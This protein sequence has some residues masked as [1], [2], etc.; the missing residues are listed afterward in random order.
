MLRPC[1]AHQLRRSLLRMLQY[2]G[3]AAV[4]CTPNLLVAA[5]LSGSFYG[6]S[7]AWLLSP[8]RCCTPVAPMGGALL[9]W[10][11]TA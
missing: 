3:V 9:K 7:W 5:I 6:M 10:A 1:P 11:A 2:Y 8:V 4:A